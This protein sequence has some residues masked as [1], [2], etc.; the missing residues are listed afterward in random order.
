MSP[1]PNHNEELIDQTSATPEVKLAK[2]LAAKLPKVALVGRTNVGKSTLW[3]RLTE[4]GRA[5]VSSDPHTTRDRNYAPVFWRGVAFQLA[6]TGGMDTEND[7]IGEGIRDQ[8]EKAIAE[9]DLVLFVV[10]AKTGILPQDMDLA[11]FVRQHHKHAWLVTNKVDNVRNLSDG[12]M[13]QWKS[14]GFGAPHLV[15]ATTSLGIGDLCDE[16]QLELDKLGKPCVSV[17]ELEPLR[18]VMVGRP[19]VGKSSLVNAILGEERVIVSPIPHTTREPQDTALVYKDRDVV[20]V[21]TAGMRKRSKVDGAIEEASI[22]RNR[23]AVDRADV[24]LLVFDATS[25]PTSQDRHLA[26]MLEESSK[27][28]ILVANKWDLVE[29]KNTV[30]TNRYEELLRQL[31]P[32]LSWAPMVF[33]SAKENLRAAKLIDIAMKVQ[34]ERHRHIDYNAVNRLLKQTI[35]KMRPLQSYGPKS[36]RIYDCAQI[37]H[38]PPTFLITVH[39]DKDNL[40]PNWLKFFEKRLREK[41]KFTGTPIVVKVR[42]LAMGKVA[43]EKTKQGEGMEAVAGKLRIKKRL[44]N[45]TRRGQKHGRSRH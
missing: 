20:L 25:D 35:Q 10:D 30:T 42:H 17:P 3:N 13:N 27:G 7:I 40:H 31:F 37:G 15:S 36:P 45:Q 26:G 2:S 33:V 22:E 8:A 23:T 44:V 39:G 28:L 21:D 4:S 9:S 12:L 1:L 38:A 29:E 34:E 5:I 16:I 18:I 32:F 24:A 11:R 14:L 41:F 19:N 43:D 6:D